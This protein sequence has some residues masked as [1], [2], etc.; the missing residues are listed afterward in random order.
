MSDPGIETYNPQGTW[1]ASALFVAVFFY[2]W[3]GLSPL[4]D[5]TGG[6]L[7]AYGESSNSF[8]QLVVFAMSFLV[9]VMLALHP[10]RLLALKA[11]V[12]LGIVFFWIAIT[13]TFSDTPDSALRR[14]VYSILVC[15]CASAVLLLPRDPNHFAKLVGLCLL[16]SVSLSYFGVI[17]LPAR[18]IHQA[19]DLSEQF[20]AGDWRGHFGHK[21]NAAAA[22]AF[23]VFF[24]LYLL[25]TRSFW[26]GL[27]LTAMAGYFLLNSGGKTSAAML[28]AV[29]VIAW[30]FER[31]GAFRIVLVGGGLAL[32]NFIILS[33]AVSP[34]INAFVT[35][36]GI[37]ATFTDRTS[38]WQLALSSIANRPFTGYGFQ[39]FWQ[40]D[41]LFYG[42]AS[43][44]TWAV[45]AANAH[46]AYVEQLINGG[47]PLLIL[48]LIW[49]VVLPTNHASAALARG[50]NPDLTR[51]YLRIWLFG[52][53]TSCFESPFFENAGPIWF[54]ILIA[55]FGLRLQAHAHLVDN[56]V[57]DMRDLRPATSS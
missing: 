7:A 55:V 57:S 47:W 54:T 4:A 39:S 43:A 48:V 20:L 23:A 14:T 36:L 29:L 52:L 50:D 9:M 49:L 17:F 46:N 19:S 33:V 40:T 30:L 12:P 18:A 1:L 34:Q 11:L 44:S 6:S 38:I 31:L 42:S 13:I 28:P 21:N 10:Q 3:I 2:F 35:G 32:V 8:N 27:L 15:I 45:T 51:L 26:L 41:A 16:A 56:A 5:M 22:M 37:D 53:F 24:G 25:K